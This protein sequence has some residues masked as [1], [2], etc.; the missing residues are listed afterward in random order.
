[1]VHTISESSI[2]LLAPSSLFAVVLII[3]LIRITRSVLSPSLLS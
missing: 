3:A 1:M 2:S